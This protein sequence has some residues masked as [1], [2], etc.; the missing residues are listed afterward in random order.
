MPD[1]LTCRGV[2]VRAGT[3]CWINRRRLVNLSITL[4]SARALCLSLSARVLLASMGCE[5]RG[6]GRDADSC[7]AESVPL[8]SPSQ[9]MV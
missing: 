5:M 2:R 3:E 8:S 7:D 9:G 1:R 4:A 6:T